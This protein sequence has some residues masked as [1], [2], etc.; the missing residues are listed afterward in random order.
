MIP[1]NRNVPRGADISLTFDRNV[2]ITLWEKY[3]PK[4]GWKMTEAYAEALCRGYVGQ[5]VPLLTY[6]RFQYIVHLLIEEGALIDKGGIRR[7]T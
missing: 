1:A 2:V 6:S 4:E 7:S 5:T 3:S